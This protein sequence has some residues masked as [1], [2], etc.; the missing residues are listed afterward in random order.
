M[1][2]R[3]I[4]AAL[5]LEDV[6]AGERLVA[7]SLASFANREQCAWPGARIA[8]ARAGLSR[9]Q[10]L[11][12]RAGLAQ[13]GLV[14][15]EGGTSS[16]TRLTFADGGRRVPGKI[17]A[18]LFEAVLSYSSTRGSARLLLASL[19]ALAD[20]SGAVVGV[21]TEDLC[22]AAGMADSTYRRSRA[23]LLD[24]GEVALQAAGGGRAKRNRWLVRDPRG[25][26][27]PPLKAPAPRRRLR[28]PATPL[29]ATVETRRSALELDGADPLRPGLDE[30]N[31]PRRT[32]GT[33][34]N[35]AQSRA[36]QNRNRARNPA[37]SRTALTETPLNPGR[38]KPETPLN[39]GRFE[40][41]TP[42]E[43]PPPN[44]RAGRESQ[45]LN[46]TPPNPPQVTNVA[47]GPQLMGEEAAI[48]RR[49]LEAWAPVLGDQLA[50]AYHR[51]RDGWER[52]AERLLKRHTHQ[53]LQA[54]FEQM[55]ADE[56]IGS[57]AT[58]LPAFERVVDRLLARRHARQQQPRS[59]TGR[60]SASGWEQARREL[61]RAI[62]R[63][64]R[65]QRQAALR[66]LADS[67]S[68]LVT[69]VERVRWAV[70]CEQPM[71]FSERRYRELWSEI[72]D[73]TSKLQTREDVA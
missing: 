73:S 50:N 5:A 72:T 45:N 41:E 38:V 9:S 47:D 43:T 36:G 8:A 1:S 53:R 55:L 68:R 33:A 10:Y 42:P 51:D 67:D 71:R 6:S 13:R 16:V 39:P 57:Q 69:F 14:D 63:Y 12:G 52:C 61:E 64:G 7:F 32:S 11:A 22:V 48:C 60:T 46:T 40:E 56:I 24:L 31:A 62:G 66:D 3:A 34:Q 20:R 37:Q 70:L 15:V 28:G 4:A 29:L 59:P 27:R 65:D 2:H 25:S 30:R 49:F 54:A 18:E 44:A 23:L 35:P 19:A 26:G 17:N 21:S 58:T